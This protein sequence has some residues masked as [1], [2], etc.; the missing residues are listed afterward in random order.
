MN[1]IEFTA[2]FGYETKQVKLVSNNCG[3]QGYQVL[4]NDFYQGEIFYNDG[5]QAHLNNKSI[6]TGD[7]IVILGEVIE[8]NLP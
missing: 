3:G 8:A 6:L 4:I 7:D 1:T 2:Q 5:W